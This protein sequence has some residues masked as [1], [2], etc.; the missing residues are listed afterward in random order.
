VIHGPTRADL[1]DQAI[2]PQPIEGAGCG[3]RPGVVSMDG[4]GPVD[5]VVDGPREETG[6]HGRAWHLWTSTVSAPH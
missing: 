5:L 6:A 2:T 3:E 1:R 4:G